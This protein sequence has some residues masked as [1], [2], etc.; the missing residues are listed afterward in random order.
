MLDES[1]RGDFEAI[2]ELDEGF[3]WI[4]DRDAADAL[5]LADPGL[6]PAEGLVAVV[7][8]VDPPGPSAHGGRA[9]PGRLDGAAGAPGDAADPAPDRRR[10]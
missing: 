5:V 4:E 3:Y 10:V 7:P 6:E 9:G 2:S 1:I 8:A